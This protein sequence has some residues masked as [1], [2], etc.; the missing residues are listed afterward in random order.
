MPEYKV[1][2]LKDNLR[3]QFR[4][5]PHLSGLMAVKPRDYEEAFT[6]EAPTPYAAWHALRG[7]ERELAI[8]DLLGID[9]E[10]L[11]I[12]KYIGFEQARWVLPEPKHPHPA[13]AGQVAEGPT[14]G[15]PVS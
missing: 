7:T 12:L 9:A 13:I 8:G 4:W 2:R 1:F 14:A 6:V 11:R 10:D 15:A 5:A 3:Q